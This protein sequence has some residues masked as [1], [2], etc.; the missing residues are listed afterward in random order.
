MEL[1]G[2]WNLRPTEILAGLPLTAA[3]LADP[4]TRVPLRVCEAIIA[5][6]HQLTHEPALALHLGMQMR[7]SAHG[8][9]GFAAMTAG[10]VRE[11]LELACRFAQTRTTVI[12]LALYVE[13]D[14]ASLVIEEKTPLDGLREFFVLALI[15]GLDQLGSALTGRVLEGWAECAFPAPAYLHGLPRTENLRFDRAAHRIVFPARELD[16]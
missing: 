7:V 1:A 5:R 16:M 3:E 12:G 13:G 8:F 11:A 15:T 6:A 2:R 10:T 14:T 9:L 4:T